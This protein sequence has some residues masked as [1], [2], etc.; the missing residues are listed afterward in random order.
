MQV[1]LPNLVARTFL[2]ATIYPKYTPCIFPW[3]LYRAVHNHL[4]VYEVHNHQAGA[5]KMQNHHDAASKFSLSLSQ[6]TILI[7][8]YVQHPAT[9]FDGS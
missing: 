1:P 3:L 6:T 8:R 9:E 4:P 5:Y 7:M 2:C